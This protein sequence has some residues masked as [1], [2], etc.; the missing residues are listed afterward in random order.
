MASLAAGGVRELPRPSLM[1]QLKAVH[2]KNMRL[3][4]VNRK[5]MARE[6]L[7]PIVLLF[8]LV[9]MRQGFSNEVFEA[10]LDHH[11]HE[12]IDPLANTTFPVVILFAPCSF[13]TP[14]PGDGGVAEAGVDAAAHVTRI[15]AMTTTPA[16]VADA[17]RVD[18]L[19]S[20]LQG[21][22]NATAPVFTACYMCADKDQD[23]CSGATVTMVD[24]Y[25]KF[26]DMDTPQV[27]GAV[28]VTD[29]TTLAPATA[30]TTPT[31]Y[32]LKMPPSQY[33]VPTTMVVQ[34]NLT[35]PDGMAGQY[36]G[37]AMTL[38][39]AVDNAIAT[40]RHLPASPS[41]Q[42]WVRKLSAQ[43]FPT[44]GYV[45]AIATQAL[46]QMLPIYLLMIFSFQVRVLVTRVLEEKEKKLKEGMRM[47]GLADEV[48]WLSWFLL[49][50]A[51]GTFFCVA[52]VCVGKFGGLFTYSDPILMF[53]FFFL[54]NCV[55][56]AFVFLIS[57]FFSKSKTGGAVGMLLWLALYLP[58]LAIGGASTSGPT[59]LGLSFVAPLGFS[60]GT[61]ILN[62]V[63]GNNM[64][65][66]WGNMFETSPTLS[67]QTQGA[68]FGSVLLMLLFDFVVYSFLAWYLDKVMPTE[69]GVQL[70]P[71]FLCSRSYWKRR[72][73][74]DGGPATDRSPLLKGGG[75]GGVVDGGMGDEVD[76]A[77]VQAV[78]PDVA[79]RP[80]VRIQ[81][82][83][84]EFDGQEGKKTAVDRLT[85]SMYEGQITA[86]LGHNGAG[87]ST[88]ISMLTG[89]FPPTSGDAVV[90]GR[91][92][93]EDIVGVRQLTGVCPQHDV[94]FDLLTVREHLELFAGIKGM[95]PEAAGP[96]IR[97]LAADVDL[98]DKFNSKSKTLSGGQKRRLSVAIALVGNPK[99]L[100]LDEPTSGAYSVLRVAVLMRR[101]LPLMQE[102]LSLL[103]LS[104]LLLVLVLACECACA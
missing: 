103:S 79:A 73:G 101:L 81:R 49:A 2:V 97:K 92:I 5:D 64:G 60:L 65:V 61:V 96:H 91:S 82:L 87:K 8:A 16:P 57:T 86:L 94:L 100:F 14:L 71:T 74:S 50:M 20:T 55:C 26:Q 99:V 95:V 78:G 35:G 22:A 83:V 52:I 80:G 34:T 25:N 56:V 89:L 9:M 32:T 37:T 40:M 47:M 31:E 66:H 1:T 90:Y 21:A 10:T 45:V 76:A 6:F 33:G 75:D 7:W 93:V 46:A 18:S 62:E 48:F 70:K 24:A 59:K 43:S 27:M 28:I 3:M 23:G 30:A 11:D 98:L 36:A 58:M 102:Q 38:Q 51:K 29:P 53:L 42:G 19:A 17:H 39:R 77:D 69:F 88:T 41:A 85:V 4:L 67:G 54:F 104:L 63:N 15:M 72:S 13:D 44:G 84:K 68:S 12:T